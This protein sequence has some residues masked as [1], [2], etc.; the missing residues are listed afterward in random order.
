MRLT[1]P[2]AFC[3]ARAALATRVRAGR[4]PAIG[5]VRRRRR[6]GDLGRPELRRLPYAT[7]FPVQPNGQRTVNQEY[8]GNS[9][10]PVPPVFSRSF[11][12]SA[13]PV[14]YRIR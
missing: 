3:G 1:K 12:P 8:C 2:V 4:P 6:G 10:E 13:P 5:R 11:Q 14:F 9:P 7:P